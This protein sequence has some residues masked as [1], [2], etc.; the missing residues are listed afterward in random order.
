M[1][2][3]IIMTAIIITFGLVGYWCLMAHNVP[4]ISSRLISAE[5]A[6]I[7]HLTTK[8][9]QTTTQQQT[10]LKGPKKA[11]FSFLYFPPLTN[12]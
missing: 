3:N 1:M 7:N 9:T 11:L 10:T 12:P 5:I 2:I 6:K 4:I 8:A